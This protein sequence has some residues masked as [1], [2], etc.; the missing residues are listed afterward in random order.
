VSHLT[1]TPAAKAPRVVVA[2]SD[3]H[4][5]HMLR[6]LLL[7][8]YPTAVVTVVHTFAA[9]LDCVD[10]DVVVLDPLLDD[11]P[12]VSPYALFPASPI[13]VAVHPADE[14][15]GLSAV[16]QGA[17]DFVLK[18]FCPPS[19][20]RRVLQNAMVRHRRVQ[21]LQSAE[22]DLQRVLETLPDGVLI[23][24]EG[25]IL[26]ANRAMGK[27]L[28]R[29]EG[30]LVGTALTGL[31][32]AEHRPL[33]DDAIVDDFPMELLLDT[34]EGQRE[35]E[36]SAPVQV[37]IAQMPATLQVVRDVSARRALETKMWMAGKLAGLGTVSVG[38]AHEVNNPLTFITQNIE[39]LRAL[40]QGPA[41]GTQGWSVDDAEEAVEV[42]EEMEEGARRIQ[43][44]VSEL[45][46][47]ARRDEAPGCVQLAQLMQW[48]KSMIHPYLGSRTQLH[49][50]VDDSVCAWASET[51]L[52]QMALHLL[53][54]AADAQRTQEPGTIRVTAEARGEQVALVVENEAL[55]V[56]PAV[57]PRVFDPNF[58]ARGTPDSSLMG[59][60]L[61]H[62]LVLGCG[63]EMIVDATTEE[64]SANGR[65]GT[66]VTLLL[67]TADAQVA[68]PPA[69][70]VG[71][72]AVDT[73]RPAASDL[74]VRQL[75]GATAAPVLSN[76]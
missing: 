5:G 75:D 66:R 38:V 61:A 29:G 24:R 16:E 43:R 26:Y 2:D 34:R 4:D 62:R 49:I 65:A 6:E 9:A 8:A 36:V 56:D 71:K 18:G 68:P 17:D 10:V 60:A 44:I 14:N 28:G 40:M 22:R 76:V 45:N 30:A 3:V 19:L 73:A 11:L 47:Y 69:D 32:A 74:K 70:L 25:R 42:L 48:G 57:L 7:Q 37:R 21:G 20:L 59:L 55:A 51:R 41:G 52:A 33:L 50:D 53:R 31:F 72:P 15:A 27:L 13:V 39:H 46:R 23:H 54:H 58:M 1:E 64:A 67:P 63:G 35:V 12:G